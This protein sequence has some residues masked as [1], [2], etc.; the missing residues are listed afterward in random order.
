MRILQFRVEGVVQGVG[1]RAFTVR[2]AIEHDLAGFV[3]NVRDGSVEGRVGGR[4]SDVEAF[5]AALREGPPGAVV[6]ALLTEAA[7]PRSLPRPFQVQ[8][9]SDTPMT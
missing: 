9:T 6:D 5:L 2:T 1:F 8:P 3:R 7:S 4:A